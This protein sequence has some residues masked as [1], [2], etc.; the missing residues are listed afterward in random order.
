MLIL[1]IILGVGCTKFPVTEENG[2]KPHDNIRGNTIPIAQE[3]VENLQ[4]NI[5]GNL[6]IRNSMVAEKGNT[7]YFTYYIAGSSDESTGLYSQEL[8]DTL[9]KTLV[10]NESS[11]LL[12]QVSGDFVY[13]LS[14]GK[15]LCRINTKAREAKEE[16]VAP[17][18]G[19]YSIY[20]H[21]AYFWKG[22]EDSLYFM[23]LTDIKN[24]PRKIAEARPV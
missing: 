18:A 22:T 14:S 1:S 21:W 5:L 12:P 23:D 20:D 24:P 10:T 19:S 6:V 7:H 16:V 15:G 8:D 2:Q 3:N 9:A 13:Y 17:S 11:I 4:G